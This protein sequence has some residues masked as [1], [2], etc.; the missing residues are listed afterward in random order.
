MARRRVPSAGK[1]QAASEERSS[2]SESAM[3]C[4]MGCLKANLPGAASIIIPDGTSRNMDLHPMSPHSAMAVTACMS[5]AKNEASAAE[6]L[7]TSAGDGGANCPR[8]CRRRMHYR[9][10]MFRLC[11]SALAS[12]WDAAT[13]THTRAAM[14]K[15]LATCD[16]QSAQGPH[17]A[18]NSW[19]LRKSER[20]I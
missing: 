13:T 16:M 19:N 6:S 20:E 5:A 8:N 4:R 12:T 14:R 3:T 15:S 1:E 17:W 10:D 9:Q 11:F 18:T 2:S 7:C